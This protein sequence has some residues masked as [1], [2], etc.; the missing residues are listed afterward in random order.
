MAT[1]LADNAFGTL[2]SG[3][4][5]SDTTLN[6]TAGHGARFPAVTAPDVL[7]CCILNA[8]NIL[9]EVQITAHTVNADSCT[10][11]RAQGG[12]TAKVWNAGDRIEARVSKTTLQTMAVAAVSGGAAG[13]IVCQV[14]TSTT[15]FSALGTATDVLISQGTGVPTWM[16]LSTFHAPITNSLAADVALSNTANYFDGP[17]VAQGT[18]GTW[19]VSGNV[20]CYDSTNVESYWVKLWDGN[21]VIDEG[22]DNSAIGN[23]AHIH[24]SGYIINPIGNLRISVRT[25]SNTTAII[26]ADSLGSGNKKSCTITAI[27]IG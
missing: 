11:V 27:R 7:Y 19:F 23:N 4:L 24:L 2:G 10:I 1:L 21:T 8:S 25:P 12:T 18:S 20:Q 13:A 3:L 16:K 9:E 15:S 6:F 17:S 5:T 22:A 14:G 26:R